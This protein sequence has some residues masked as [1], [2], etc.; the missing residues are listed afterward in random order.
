MIKTARQTTTGYEFKVKV[1]IIWYSYYSSYDIEQ[2]IKLIRAP[3]HKNIQNE[4]TCIYVYL[5]H[6]YLQQRFC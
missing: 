6:N 1:L 3:C 4:D 5:K 2:F